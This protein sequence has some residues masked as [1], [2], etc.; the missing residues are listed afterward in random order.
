[1]IVSGFALADVANEKYPLTDLYE[2]IIIYLDVYIPVYV[3]LYS[4]NS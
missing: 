4:G 2:G 3:R 1:M